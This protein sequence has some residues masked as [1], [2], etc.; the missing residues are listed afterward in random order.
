MTEIPPE[1]HEALMA[2]ASVAARKK[3]LMDVQFIM[4]FHNYQPSCVPAI[5]AFIEKEL[6][7]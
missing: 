3:A 4:L 2:I 5:K 1:T 7:K 6:S